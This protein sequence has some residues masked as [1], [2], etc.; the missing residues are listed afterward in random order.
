MNA[1]SNFG[2]SRSAGDPG[3][4]LDELDIAILQVL[5]RSGRASN[6]EI[7]EIVGLSPSAASRRIQALE[8]SGVILGY[9]A[10]VDESRLGRGMT[11]FVRVTLERQSATAL[12]AFE[13]GVKKFG[14]V[15]FCHLM[16][17][18]YD[19]LL[20][21]KVAD[22]SDYER[23]HRQELSSLPGV[24]R[25]ESSFSVRDVIDSGRPHRSVNAP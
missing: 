18:Q 2:I 12:N 11:V 16:A 4:A 21:I 10:V 22:M 3:G 13:C 25:I 19:Y 1:E 23:L 5:Q 24:A 7:G 14:S 6:Q 15:F 9:Q 17:G 20:Q 8:N